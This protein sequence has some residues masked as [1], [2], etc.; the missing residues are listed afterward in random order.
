[1][2][3]AVE[4]VQKQLEAYNNKDV[5]AWLST[6]AKDAIQYSMEGEVLASG[7][8]EMKQ[9]IVIR[10][11]EK[12]LFAEL[13]NRIVCEDMI[14]DLE[15]ITRNF[16]EGKGTIEMLCI[17]HVENDLIKKGQFKVFN[18]VVFGADES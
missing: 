14:I 7:H 4:I 9:N 10:F 18:K 11:K 5:Q 2:T 3:S 16:P 13:K 6:Y 17:Y 8:N 15:L 1:M 12:E